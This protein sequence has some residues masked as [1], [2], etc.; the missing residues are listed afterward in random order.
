MVKFFPYLIALLA[1][2]PGSLSIGLI[3][4]KFNKKDVMQR[5][6]F[7]SMGLYAFIT[8]VYMFTGQDSISI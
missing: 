7:L 5:T 3:S 2:I 4:K 6:Q 8:V 1:V